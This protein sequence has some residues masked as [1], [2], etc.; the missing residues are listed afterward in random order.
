MQ[1]CSRQEM[2]YTNCMEPNPYWEADS[3]SAGQ[4]IPRILW[5]PRIHYRAHKEQPL[6]PILSH[7]NLVHNLEL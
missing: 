4:D 3:R 1:L 7:M 6:V 5:K 2:R